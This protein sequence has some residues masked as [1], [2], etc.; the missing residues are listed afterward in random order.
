ML[1]TLDASDETSALTEQGA[2]SAWF[3]VDLKDGNLNNTGNSRIGVRATLNVTSGSYRVTLVGDTSPSLSGRC[4]AADVTD[5]T[6]LSKSAIWGSY[7]PIAAKTRLLTFHVEHLS[8]DCEATWTLNVVG[9]PCPAASIGFGEN[10]LGS[11]PP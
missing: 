8:G 4:T 9:N 1:G 5:T 11:C 2:G 6:P 3:S 7:G 10:S